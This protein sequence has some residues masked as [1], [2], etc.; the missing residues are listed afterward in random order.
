RKVPRD[1]TEA[2]LA[3]GGLSLISAFI[4]TY[5]FVTNIAQY[6]ATLHTTSIV[7]DRSGD[8]RL[9]LNFNITFPHLACR[10]ASVD[11]S[12]VMGTQILNVSRA[13]QKHHIDGEG[14]FVG[15]VEDRAKELV[16][17]EAQKKGANARNDGHSVEV[18]DTA[19]FEKLV[20][21]TDL[22]LVNFYAPWCPWC[23]RLAPVWEEASEQLA[24]KPY[25]SSVTLVKV[26]CTTSSATELCKSQH[27]HAL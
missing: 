15:M 4:M 11:V 6:I 18:F 21:E 26:D 17:G 25:A 27:V 7:L 9:Q 5:L 12:D 24:A 20:G 2:T 19:A 3:G 23:Q 16:Y 13:V 14:R 8:H 10:F 1:L 22:V